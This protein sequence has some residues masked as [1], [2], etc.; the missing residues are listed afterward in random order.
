[1][2]SCL[3][4]GANGFIGRHLVGLLLERGDDVVG[5]I[6]PTSDTSSLVPLFERH[7]S[8]LRLILGDL[9]EPATLAEGVEGV[10][11]VFHLAAVLLGT[12]EAEFRDTIVQGTANLLAAIES[13]SSDATLKRFLYVSSLAAVGPSPPDQS[14][15]EEA[16]CRPVSWYGAAKRDAE[17][18]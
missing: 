15:T 10:D 18:L 1:M 17:A 14:L 6:R 2:S 4:T 9:R 5:L 3:V 8:R 16:P 11:H 13:R 12:T 7:G